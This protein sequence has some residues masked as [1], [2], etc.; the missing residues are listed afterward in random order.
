MDSYN[1]SSRAMIV[2]ISALS[3]RDGLHGLV[4]GCFRQLKRWRDR[5]GSEH[6]IDPGRTVPHFNSAADLS[7][8]RGQRKDSRKAL[9]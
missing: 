2:R 5:P 7:G 1:E 9:C 6:E 8:T 3:N 4:R